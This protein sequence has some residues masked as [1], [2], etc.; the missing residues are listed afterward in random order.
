MQTYRIYTEDT[1]R[2]TIREI[3]SA[4]FESYTMIP[5]M[6]VW[7]GSTENTV[8]IEILD[9]EHREKDIYAVAEMIRY[10]NHQEAVLVTR[11]F[12]R[13]DDWVMIK[14]EPNAERK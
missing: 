12:I 7:K 1:S 4:Q 9:D 2:D 13:Y 5:C 3:V 8:I 10:I 6:G 11:S 14:G